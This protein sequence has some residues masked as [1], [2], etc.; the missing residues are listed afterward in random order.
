MTN[1][2]GIGEGKVIIPA[3]GKKKIPDLLMGSE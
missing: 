1:C 3:P 2:M